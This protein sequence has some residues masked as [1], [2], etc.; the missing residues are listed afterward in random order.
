M[1]TTQDT[2][3]ASRV[4]LELRRRLEDLVATGRFVNPRT[5]APDLS[6]VIVT[7]LERGVDREEGRA[8]LERRPGTAH[9]NGRPTERR[10]AE[11]T[12][13]RGTQRFLALDYFAHRGE[14]GATTDEVVAALEERARVAGERI[15]APNSTPRRVTDLLEAGAIEAKVY[16][17]SESGEEP[18][19]RRTRHGRDAQVWTITTKG[20]EWLT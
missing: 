17:D 13:A 3:I 1:G 16:A 20:R 2:T 14:E 12:P 19:T 6:T 7:L 9:R 11:S 15:P 4:P 5:G 18:V 10:A 8:E